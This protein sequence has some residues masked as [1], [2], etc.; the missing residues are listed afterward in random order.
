MHAKPNIGTPLIGALMRMPVD[1][2]RIRMLSALHERGFTDLVPAHLIVLRYPGPNGRRPVEIAAQSGMSKQALNYL[3]G[4]L[5][6]AG[7]LTRVDDRDDR[8][9]KRVY[10]TPRGEAAIGVMRATVTTVEREFAKTFGAD[11]LD[12]LRS[13][14]A[15][16]NALLG[17]RAST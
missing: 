15:R 16:L 12:A 17:T 2:I 10:T 4:Q 7:Y 8:R 5:E 9:S 3:L 6:E 11:E 13:L 14:L 1:A